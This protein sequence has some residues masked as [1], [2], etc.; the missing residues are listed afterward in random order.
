MFVI[1][2]V[3][4]GKEI[5]ACCVRRNCL[6]FGTGDGRLYEVEVQFMGITLIE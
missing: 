5:T 6:Y 3:Y 4:R 1:V 2:C